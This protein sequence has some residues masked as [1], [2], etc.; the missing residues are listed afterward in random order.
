[1]TV[2]SEGQAINFP[3]RTQLGMPL[4]VIVG[5]DEV[6]LRHGKLILF[7]GGLAHQMPKKFS[8]VKK[9]T[10]G[11]IHYLAGIDIDSESQVRF[12]V[13]L[14]LPSEKYK[15]IREMGM[16]GNTPQEIS[17]HVIGLQ[18]DA[19]WDI[20]DVGAMLLVEDFAFS[21]PMNTQEV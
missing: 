12:D 5:D 17:L 8:S 11:L 1:M 13:K 3:V 18:A 4:T 21:Y 19:R 6:M 20:G 15:I 16:H 10:F 2:G 14:Y 7:D 9:P